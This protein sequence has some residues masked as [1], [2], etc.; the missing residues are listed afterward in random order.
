MNAN[1]KYGSLFCRRM[2]ALVA[3]V[4]PFVG[5]CA[6]RTV[7]IDSAANAYPTEDI[8]L[9]SGSRVEVKY[10]YRG[11]AKTMKEALIDKIKVNPT[12]DGSVPHVAFVVEGEGLKNDVD[13]SE[14]PHL[15][16]SAPPKGASWQ[17][18]MYQVLE[19][20][21]EPFG[22]VYRFGYYGTAWAGESGIL[23]TNLV[24]NPLTGAPRSVVL[25]G[26]GTTCIRSISGG[27]FT[28]TG[29]LTVGEGADIC[30]SST[31]GYGNIS[32][33]TFKNNSRFICKTITASL[34]TQ[35]LVSF[36]GTVSISV[37]GGGSVAEPPKLSING[38]VSGSGT[39]KLIDQGGIAFI[40][41]NNTYSG[42]IKSTN[43][44]E[45]EIPQ[46]MQVGNGAK[47]SWGTGTFETKRGRE[48]VL[49]NADS[50]LTCTA[51]VTG[52]GRLVKRGKGV[53][54]LTNPP[55]RTAAVA[56]GLYALEIENGGIALG[57]E[58]PAPM[59]GVMRLSSSASSFDACG[60]AD[61][62][63]L[64]EGSGQVRSTGGSSLMLKGGW[65]NDVVFSGALACP[66]VV[67]ALGGTTW[68]LTEKTSLADNLEIRSGTAAMG[69]FFA[70]DHDVTVGEAATLKFNADD[71]WHRKTL[72]GLKVDFWD[73]A[74]KLS[75]GT[76]PEWLE[77][78][79]E[80]SESQLPMYSTD[81]TEFPRVQNGDNVNG[82]D[83]DCPFAKV[84]GAYNATKYGTD[85]NYFAA[86]FSGFLHIEKAGTYQ[87]RMRADDSGIV[88]LNGERIIKI[89]YGNSGSVSPTVSRELTA[90]D[91]PF[92]VLFCEESGWDVMMV[93]MQGPDVPDWQCVPVTMLR[94]CVDNGIS[95]GALKGA[96]QIGL[97][98]NGIWPAAMPTE[99]FTGKVIVDDRTKPET[100]GTL[101]L[102][103]ATLDLN[104]GWDV[105]G[106]NWTLC[107]AAVFDST[108]GRTAIRATPG[109]AT[110]NGGVNTSNPIPVTG[111][112][113]VEFDFS[114][115]EPFSG[116]N[117]GDGFVIVLHN[118]G[119]NQTTG[120]LFQYTEAS[121][122]IN[123]DSAYG[124]QCFINRDWNYSVWMKNGNAYAAAGG[125]ETN[126]TRFTMNK[127]KNH[128]MHMKMEYD[129]REKMIVTYAVDDIVLARTNACA[130]A[131][132]AALFPN[133]ARLGVW[134]AN[135]AAYASACIDDLTL[136]LPGVTDA[137]RPEFGGTLELKGGV[138]TVVGHPDGVLSGKL[139]VTGAA[140]LSSEV[141]LNMTSSSWTFTPGTGMLSVSGSCRLADFV[142]VELAG[143]APKGQ[144]LLADF[145]AI[146]CEL[147]TATLGAGYP[148]K[149]SLSWLGRQL[150]L[151]RAGGMVLIFK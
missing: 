46:L 5:F 39:I 119:A 94:P 52:P 50:N 88:W 18:S 103:S 79:Q 133:G 128:P 75:S 22:D 123:C 24:D 96:G 116:S 143:E 8:E 43:T 70:T 91:H 2:F 48:C 80:T 112:W 13:F 56:A 132:L 16:L 120:G 28:F 95:L 59:Q 32:Q 44:S 135:G 87:F 122:R 110:Q 98:A 41:T 142:T 106:T 30:T 101:A 104:N 124:I 82:S 66:A 14:Q 38:D 1:L 12:S 10:S 20:R 113:S 107:G 31:T 17:S 105:T 27:K 84:L 55:D 115:V 3:G 40:G 134:A 121:K 118:G 149:L 67:E 58:V 90:G 100:S 138:L 139:A 19:G 7:T 53:L 83:K 145:S 111:P 109:A 89:T 21:Y 108:L 114:A 85:P 93:E 62:A 72:K 146:D 140:T 102:S 129:G 127:I 23:V 125:F 92:K 51:S 68:R 97:E 29:S 15:W 45:G 74:G 148:K 136:T 63:Y 131:D 147:P 33:I 76:H 69:A 34:A 81:M 25:E 26:T 86:V 35:T 73:L 47:F 150:Y 137:I 99:G 78:A 130:G 151:D 42:T 11:G 49:F 6:V 4:A 54:T 71:Y 141:A 126:T 64:P 117:I 57:G 65:T 36:D 37:N 77:A 61:V 9:D 144:T 60:R